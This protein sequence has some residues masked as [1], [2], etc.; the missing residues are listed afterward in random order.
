MSTFHQR[1]LE[2]EYNY[3]N[4]NNTFEEDDEGND[5][6]F[7][8]DE[9]TSPVNAILNVS[10]NNSE[11]RINSIKASDESFSQYFLQ[12]TNSTSSSVIFHNDE[13]E[14]QG[15]S[16]ESMY[17]D[18]C[19]SGSI[20]SSN[21]LQAATKKKKQKRSSYSSTSMNSHCG[22]C[23]G[24]Y[25]PYLLTFSSSSFEGDRDS[26]SRTMNTTVST[27]SSSTSFASSNGGYEST[28]TSSPV[29][30]LSSRKD[31]KDTNR[32]EETIKVPKPFRTT[33]LQHNHDNMKFDS[34]EKYDLY[35]RRSLYDSFDSTSSNSNND[36]KRSNQQRLLLTE[37]T[38]DE[39]ETTKSHSK[40]PK[41]RRN[42]SPMNT[43][44]MTPTKNTISSTASSTTPRRRR[45]PSNTDS[46]NLL[47][48]PPRYP[49]A[50]LSTPPRPIKLSTLSSESF[51]LPSPTSMKFTP[52]SNKIRAEHSKTE[53]SC[54]NL[55]S[56]ASLFSLSY[57]EKRDL[58]DVDITKPLQNSQLNF[59][60]PSYK[61]NDKNKSITGEVTHN[62]QDLD[63][64][65]HLI[66]DDDC[67]VR[68][69]NMQ[70]TQYN[71]IHYGTPPMKTRKTSLQS[72]DDI[73]EQKQTTTKEDKLSIIINNEGIETNQVLYQLRKEWE[74]EPPQKDVDNAAIFEAHCT[75]NHERDEQK[76]KTLMQKTSKK[77]KKMLKRNKDTNR[78]RGDS[79]HGDTSVVSDDAA[80]AGD[81][82]T[83]HERSASSLSSQQF[84]DLWLKKIM[85]GEEIFLNHSKENI[86]LGT[87]LQIGMRDAIG[88]N[89]SNR[90]AKK[91]SGNV[92]SPLKV[93][94]SQSFSFGTKQNKVKRVGSDILNKVGT[95]TRKFAT[96]MTNLKHRH[97]L[98]NQSNILLS[99][100]DGPS[101][102]RLKSTLYRAIPT[103]TKDDAIKGRLDGIDV[104]S[105]GSCRCVSY[106]G[107]KDKALA[108]QRYTLRSM[109]SD[110]IWATLNVFPEMVLEGFAPNGND[111][112][113]V[114]IEEDSSSDDVTSMRQKVMRQRN[115]M[116]KQSHKSSIRSNR[117]NGDDEN[118]SSKL[119]P[120]P[121]LMT[122][123]WGK[124]GPPPP[125]NSLQFERADHEYESKP[126]CGLRALS[127]C[128]IHS[129]KDIFL[130]Q[131][132]DHL[133]SV[134][135]FAVV[136]LKVSLF[137]PSIPIIS[138]QLVLKSSLFYS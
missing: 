45:K 87:P 51:K 55:F 25:L 40:P 107:S 109:V 86:L 57:D 82:S 21:T 69:S 95:P 48:T 121:L 122:Q 93:K 84:A 9:S 35:S 1:F 50:T 16:F 6:Y 49:N 137:I 126:G 44:T 85:D 32:E 36:E 64:E 33:D 5:T 29:K 79:R 111:R 96:M 90:K 63:E 66:E 31:K 3:R 80:V 26:L 134:H 4:N 91:T 14:E 17:S 132:S 117:E 81:A 74:V 34:S 15:G 73:C 67:T 62:I 120:T 59:T 11:G 58:E 46:K 71:K 98:S 23:F 12:H 20:M 43:N 124:E 94:K 13:E 65:E 103:R 77:V 112:W 89:G 131:E 100:D 118:Y 113:T 10:T 106:I 22:I 119:I 138:Q 30:R 110:T 133:H 130:I 39:D 70:S 53:M 56:P 101:P 129:E 108:G 2:E 52:K 18:N 92:R 28:P 27:S 24:D 72:N 114:L 128:P 38:Y 123:I 37:S 47:A 61:N 88:S 78:G 60:L 41:A 75:K 115:K 105:L 136:P 54:S 7:Q 76:K 68:M 83:Q 125:T 102:S 135:S 8:E 99:K 97:T 42:S 116:K 19:S 104:I 127:S